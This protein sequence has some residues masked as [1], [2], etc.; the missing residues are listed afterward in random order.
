MRKN[1]CRWTHELSHEPKDS[2]IKIGR[3]HEAR[4]I[5]EAPI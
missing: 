5:L 2:M 4:R 1:L 3:E